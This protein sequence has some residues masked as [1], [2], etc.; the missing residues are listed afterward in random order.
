[1][2]VA[3]V[4]GG[5]AGLALACGLCSRDLPVRVRIYEAAP[6][7]RTATSTLIDLG[8]NAFSALEALHPGIVPAL[9]EA[10][11]L[12]MRVV[13]HRY[14]KQPNAVQLEEEVTSFQGRPEG[15]S[16]GLRWS[17]VQRV[18][19]DLVP[20]EVVQCG[21]RVTGFT[22]V[23]GGVLL[24]FKDKPDV[25]ARLAVAAD[26][27]R[28]ALRATMLP[29][30]P[31]PRYLGHMNW[32]ALLYNPDN[33][34]V[35]AHQ[36]GEMQVH[37]NGFMGDSGQWDRSVYVLDAGG[38]YTFWQLRIPSPQP[39]FTQATEGTSDFSAEPKLAQLVGGGLGIPGSK[40][41]V[42]QLLTAAG[43][44]LPLRIVQ[45]TPE[46]AIFE[47]GLLD[48]V[49]LDELGAGLASAGGRV[50]L[51]G[52]A[53]HAMHP[54]PGQGA[55]TAFEDAHQLMEALLHH[56]PPCSAAH[57]QQPR[58]HTGSLGSDL[59]PHKHSGDDEGNTVPVDN[60]RTELSE[61]TSPLACTVAEEQ[62][63]L[64]NVANQ[65]QAARLARICRLQRYAAENCGLA[66][67][68]EPLRA[69]SGDLTPEDRRPRLTELFKWLSQY[70][71]NPTGDPD[72][73]F[74]APVTAP[75][76]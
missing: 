4:G 61:A 3:I 49:P 47:R 48:R 62:D 5:L 28:S 1:V 11:S 34:V 56:W 57:S 73:R 59:A 26:G 6:Q 13:F 38:G 36:P 72:S 69:A 64:L 40:A 76:A 55:R 7:L 70:P 60:K 66:S 42:E 31:G 12:R 45:A 58:P 8:G 54:G 25:L 65:Y 21:Y 16:Y 50:L 10:G 2:D 14:S 75:P 23:E 35:D 63:A 22:E 53:A 44:E 74:W 27:V 17:E 67:I 20:P 37:I 9:K 29:Q 33:S 41:R 32:N 46:S 15:R 19:A 52:D 51:L 39:A 71:S 24:H 18:L 30:D 43:F 68:Y